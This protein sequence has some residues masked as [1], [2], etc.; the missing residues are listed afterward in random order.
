MSDD[1]LENIE[2]L[3]NYFDSMTEDVFY[4]KEKIS[5][6]YFPTKFKISFEGCHIAICKNGGLIGI[7]KKKNFLDTQRNSKLNKN[8]LV[9]RQNGN[10][11]STIP[12]TWNNNERYIVSFDFTDNEKLYGICYDGA[13][14]KFDI[15][16]SKAKE[17]P[18]SQIFKQSKIYKAK[19]IEKGFI[20]LTYDGTF[21]YVK[22]FKNIYPIAL[23][24]M[25]SLLE[26]SNEIDFVGIPASNSK[27]HKLELIFTNEK[28]NGIIH[29]MEQPEGFNYQILP[30]ENS[31]DITI[32]EV[33]ILENYELEQYI[34][35]SDD[36]ININNDNNNNI[37]D[38]EI[39]NV[40]DTR[41]NKDNIGK[42]VA[43]AISPSYEKIALY[44]NEGK[45][46][47][48]SSKFNKERKETFF[49]VNEELSE[50]DK[51]EQKAI[52]NLNN[53]N[54]YQFLF[55]G[56]DAIALSG[57][58]FILIV[59][60]LKKTL[61]YKIVE[62]EKFR[63]MQGGV[64]TKC[65]S[66]IDGLRFITN[67][68][69]FFISK[70]DND[71]YKISD[72]FSTNPAKDLLKAYKNDLMK[73]ANSDKIIR[74]IYKSLSKSIMICA[75]ASAN[76]FWVEK[77]DI[78]NKK[79]TQFFILKAAQLGK[80]F[81]DTK[82]FNYLKFNEICQS[83][84][85]I[86]ELRNNEK[87]PIFITYKEFR[88]ISLKQLIKNIMAQLNFKLAYVIS[89]YLGYSTKKIYQKWAFCK[90]KKLSYNSTK[91]KQIIL[92]NEIISELKNIKK[93]SYIK[94]AKKAFN[95]K[96]NELGLKF[97][98]LEKSILV[99]IPQYLTHHKW[100]KALELSYETY[101][102]DIIATA[103]NE[104][105]NYNMI[106]EEFIDKIKDI[107]N[108]RYSVI[109]YLKKNSPSYIDN[110]IE[111]QNDY[112][113]LM[114][115]MLEK[116]FTSNKYKDKKKYIK[117][118]QEN[119]K[120]LDKNNINNKFYSL[121]LTELENSIEFKKNCIDEKSIIKKTY[122]EPFDN[123]IYD[124]YKL[125]VKENSFNWIEKQNKNYELNSKK[126][127]VMRIRTMAENGKIDMVDKMVKDS[128]LKKLNL[129][130]LNLAELYFDYKKYDLAV[131]YIRQM[132]NSDYFEYKVDM[133][134]YMEK[135]ED[136]LD[137]IL[138]SKNMD[139]IPELVNEILNKKP[140]LEKIVKDLCTKYKV[141]L[142]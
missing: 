120:K 128:S 77:E 12:I 7:C 91:E 48:F 111:A 69:V 132:N 117:K 135:Y 10:I 99:K 2:N 34:K 14:Y 46:Y 121:Y 52:I 126:M 22:E 19:F 68:G 67:D 62:G 28:G 65:I 104:I 75:N 3:S 122:I 4:M 137:V 129:T 47:I 58:R 40:I 102:S 41:N 107:K 101:D 64:F 115:V 134:L 74:D 13:I 71:L 18:T 31:T 108:I 23:F 139:R 50:S 109:D 136:A 6:F 124:C 118:A 85:I 25:H 119:Q 32:N 21:Y 57:Q 27:S 112:E 114:F 26:F 84:R 42:I 141:N 44:N 98:E 89:K 110:Y 8:V 131:E 38:E 94:L 92:F 59:N 138:S 100:D 49:K 86:N 43:I 1:P 96:H 127:A 76:L 106:D 60:N 82:D 113:E 123:S 73:E 37:N 53:D 88:E 125:G 9:M 56:E 95:Y 61:S 72:P 103:L 30:L 16:L 35:N 36:I 130:P 70:L 24:Q 80:Y 63:A 20:A 17:K 97:L 66:E 105:V 15:L 81:V 116:F 90:I 140:N 133:L 83:I 45:I 142:N 29:V 51:N 55:C 87:S 78:D 93:I 39:N 33:S 5:N 79:Q 11:V 54:N